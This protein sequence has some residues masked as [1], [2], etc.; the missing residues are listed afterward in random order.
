[1]SM[2]IRESLRIL[3][4]TRDQYAKVIECHGLY[5]SV[6]ADSPPIRD[7]VGLTAAYTKMLVE[8]D[9]YIIAFR[10]ECADYL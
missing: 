1:M 5:G 8:I 4:R 9:A 6:T 7:V 10:K 3:E 2:S